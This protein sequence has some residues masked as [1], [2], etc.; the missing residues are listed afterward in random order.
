MTSCAV[1]SWLDFRTVTLPTLGGTLPLTSTP[2]SCPTWSMIVEG[3]EGDGPVLGR[4]RGPAA[5]DDREQG[6]LGQS[7]G[8]RPE[9]LYLGPLE[10]LER[11]A[12][13]QLAKA[14]GRRSGERRRLRRQGLFELALNVDAAVERVGHEPRQRHLNVV[15][16]EHLRA[17]ARPG[18]RL[19]ELT[20]DP[21]REH[22]KEPDYRPEDDEGSYE[23]TVLAMRAVAGADP[24]TR[25]P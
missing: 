8:L 3:I 12:V 1:E 23:S 2:T 11:Q 17:R 14:A 9:V 5:L 4:D 7:V 22:R 18:I 16:L 10:R 24:S 21:N 25:S 20:A 13:G 19:Q 15:V 6:L